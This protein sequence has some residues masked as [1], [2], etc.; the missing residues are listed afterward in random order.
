MGAGHA[1]AGGGLRIHSPY[2]SLCRLCPGQVDQYKGK[3]DLESL[4]EYVA[5]Q[6]QSTERGAPE[7]IQPS[8]APTL[9]TEP[10][11]DQ[12]GA[13]S[14]PTSKRQRR[15]STRSV[16]HMGGLGSTFQHS[17]FLNSFHMLVRGSA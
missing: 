14:A 7:P 6:L 8:E 4:R 1:W 2:V 10:T 15:H 17:V 9:A 3:R 5:S 12:V 16:I 13:R 11:A